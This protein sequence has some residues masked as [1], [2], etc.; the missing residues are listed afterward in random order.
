MDTFTELPLEIQNEILINNPL[1]P[2]INKQIYDKN[3]FYQK[4]CNLPI[5]H[6]EF[7]NYINKVNPNT[8]IIYFTATDDQDMPELNTFIFRKKN[9]IYKVYQY[10]L[11]ID[12]IDVEEYS[13]NIHSFVKQISTLSNFLSEYHFDNVYYDLITTYN[14]FKSRQC[15]TINQN[16]A[17]EQTIKIMSKKTPFL[18][19]EDLY[20]FFDLIKKL[21]YLHTNDLLLKN[22]YINTIIHYTVSNIIFDPTGEM[23]DDNFDKIQ[24][25]VDHYV[26]YKPRLIEMI[27]E[28]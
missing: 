18:E 6:E 21:I 20:S 2:R 19:V 24:T 16:Y 3:L 15:Q 28:L 4:Y 22:E 13:L 11:S 23:I 8:F 12:N 25:M 9:N 27:K 10:M 7:I 14:I 5:S 17:G 26:N 1:Y